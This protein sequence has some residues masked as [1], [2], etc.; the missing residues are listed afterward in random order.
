MLNFEEQERVT[1]ALHDRCGTLQEY[2]LH[3]RGIWCRAW[4]YF[5]NRGPN[6]PAPLNLRNDLGELLL[7]GA[8][9]CSLV[10]ALIVLRL[11]SR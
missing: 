11:T 6:L 8:A 5:M 1:A 3:V 4:L 2:G 10:L 7:A 9:P